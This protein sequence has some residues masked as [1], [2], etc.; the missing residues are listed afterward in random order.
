MAIPV[1]M[2]RLHEAELAAGMSALG[3]EQ[4]RAQI[5]EAGACARAVAAASHRRRGVETECN[6]VPSSAMMGKEP[7]SA[8]ARVTSA[9]STSLAGPQ[10]TARP[11][12]SASTAPASQNADSSTVNWWDVQ[13]EPCRSR[14]WR[15]GATSCKT[16]AGT[17]DPHAPAIRSVR[18]ACG[19]SILRPTQM[20]TAPAFQGEAT[21]PKSC[22]HATD[23]L[24]QFLVAPGS[25]VRTG[26]NSNGGLW[27]DR[28]QDG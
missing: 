20:L 17:V 15:L 16:G 25:E 19:A 26:H 27:R 2:T 8:I 7:G 13:A 24:A 4:Q 9:I 10:L 12:K 22:A 11:V 3:P 28:V 1:P 18:A 6:R 23:A 14:L 21:T 5:A